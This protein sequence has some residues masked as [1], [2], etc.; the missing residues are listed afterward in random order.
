MGFSLRKTELV[1]AVLERSFSD[2][3]SKC[4][5]VGE[6]DPKPGLPACPQGISAVKAL[7][8][9][10]AQ[11]QRIY[12]ITQKVFQDNLGLVTS[13]LSA[14]SWDTRQ[15]VQ[16]AL[17]AGQEV[18]IHQR[19]VMQDGWAG[20][21]FV[22]LDP[23]TGAGRYLIEGGGNGGQFA[24][25]VGLGSLLIAAGLIVGEAY[26][27]LAA[28]VFG[29][30]PLMIL[31]LSAVLFSLIVLTVAMYYLESGNPCLASG[32]GFA[33]SIPCLRLSSIFSFAFAV[34]GWVLPTDPVW[35]CVG[36]GR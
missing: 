5:L 7:A 15:R 20:A 32:I 30:G 8:L 11:G 12:T 27:A 13:H 9:A 21:G 24:L 18:T 28:A 31:V 33:A 1:Q 10:A 19:P 3:A 22:L 25:G 34:F 23:E 35:A 14:H 16:Q 2:R 36:G 4:N 17:E 26:A 6:P 29:L